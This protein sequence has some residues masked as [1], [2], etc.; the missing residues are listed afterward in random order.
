MG[1]FNQNGKGYMDVAILYQLYKD[2]ADKGGIVQVSSIGGF[3]N[4]AKNMLIIA[5]P[6]QVYEEINFQFL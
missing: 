1:K 4:M 3:E 6:D 2:T 5:G